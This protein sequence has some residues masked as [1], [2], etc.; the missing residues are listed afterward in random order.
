MISSHLLTDLHLPTLLVT[1][2]KKFHC[3]AVP[4]T[5]KY[6]LLFDN[7]SL[8]MLVEVMGEDTKSQISYES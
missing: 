7:L 1:S 6:L 3:I 8:Y 5:V 4:I 2:F